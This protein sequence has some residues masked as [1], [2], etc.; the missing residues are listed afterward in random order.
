MNE[1][2]PNCREKKDD[3]ATIQKSEDIQIKMYFNGI[4]KLRQ[5]E[6][7]KFSHIHIVQLCRKEFIQIYI[8]F[9]EKCYKNNYS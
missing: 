1:T 8:N 3:E 5:K 4:A 7:G 9:S 2:K 6:K